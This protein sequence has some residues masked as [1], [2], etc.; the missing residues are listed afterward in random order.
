[1]KLGP[2][3]SPYLAH[4]PIATDSIEE[5]VP[6]RSKACSK[7]FSSLMNH[8]LIRPP[9]SIYGIRILAEFS[10]RGVLF[11]TKKKFN[12]CKKMIFSGLGNNKNMIK[13]YRSFLPWF[14]GWVHFPIRALAECL[15]LCHFYST[16]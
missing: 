16:L 11:N 4:L 1:M 6:P 2:S 15:S 12:S 5:K 9:S 8:H 7:R 14:V 13:L 3:P 10:V